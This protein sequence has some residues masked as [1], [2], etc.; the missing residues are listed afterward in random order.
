MEQQFLLDDPAQLALDVARHAALANGDSHCGTEYLLYGLVAT[1]RGDVVDLID[2]FAL[3]TLRVDRAIERLVTKR[4]IDPMHRGNPRLTTRAQHALRTQRLD[5]GGPTGTFEVFHGLLA[6]DESGACEVLRDLGVQPQEARRLV[7]YGIRHLS[8]DQV[9]DLLRSLDRRIDGHAGWWGPDPTRPV[10]PLGGLSHASVPI[11]TS[12]SAEVE[13]TTMGTDTSGLGFTLVVKSRRSWVLPPVF[14]PEEALIPG[15]GAR[16]NN[17]PDFFLLQV[18]LPDGTVIDNRRV[19]DRY[20]ASSPDE[21]RLLRIGQ[22]DEHISLND[23][24][25]HDQHVIT[26]DWWVWPLPDVGSIEIRVDWPAESV[27]GSASVDLSKLEV[28]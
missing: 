16:Y 13:L 4:G 28:H 20:T 17:G 24:R 9:D 18:L 3:N 21:P 19:M 14:V 1:A 11:A 2:L 15:H 25:L 22:R 10:T 5:R 6:D 27:S 7:S 12:E 26:G 8:Q 23:R